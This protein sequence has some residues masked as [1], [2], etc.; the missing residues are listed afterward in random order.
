MVEQGWCGLCRDPIIHHDPQVMAR[1][2]G[3]DAD[4]TTLDAFVKDLPVIFFHVHPPHMLFWHFWDFP[5]KTF[6]ALLH[7]VRTMEL[8]SCAIGM[9]WARLLEDALRS[10]DLYRLALSPE[11]K[12]FAPV[13]MDALATLCVR[14]WEI[15]GEDCT[16]GIVFRRQFRVD[17]T[18][19]DIAGYGC[20]DAMT[21]K[22][23]WACMTQFMEDH[24]QAP[25]D[26]GI[27][28]LYY[29]MEGYFARDPFP[30]VVRRKL[31]ETMVKVLS[32]LRYTGDYV[33]LGFKKVFRKLVRDDGPAAVQPIVDAMDANSQKCGLCVRSE[34]LFY[35]YLSWPTLE[36]FASAGLAEMGCRAELNKHIAA[37]ASRWSV[38]RMSWMQVCAFACERVHPR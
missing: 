13:V 1:I 9:S 34:S 20:G 8:S 26:C 11:N 18:D 3:H 21:R 32:R 14:H 6:M 22:Y 30:E 4:D 12:M 16:G 38:H 36:Y 27:F 25:P 2:A 23:M 28:V 31:V 7:H 29:I 24:V 15:R 19:I 33:F 5:Q 35:P 37:Y 10:F 17:F